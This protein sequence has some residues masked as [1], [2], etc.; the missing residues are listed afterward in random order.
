ELND[1]LVG[2]Q[3]LV[4]IELR[5][6]PTSLTGLRSRGPQHPPPAPNRHVLRQSDFRGHGESQFHHRSFRRRRL[7]VKENSTATQV[8]GKSGHSPSIKV[9]RQ[10]QVHFEKPRAS[11]FQTI[12]I[13]AHH[14][15]FP[16]P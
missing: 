8:Q 14:T 11:P 12:G 4:G 3:V 2:G 7:R 1:G 6:D 10:R 16:H 15:S 5:G 13:C 9:N